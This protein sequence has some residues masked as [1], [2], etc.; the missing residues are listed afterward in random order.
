M[1]AERLLLFLLC[2]HLGSNSVHREAEG[3]RGS[4]G[5]PTPHA[6]QNF[7]PAKT[8]RQP[9]QQT[10]SAPRSSAVSWGSSVPT[11][12]QAAQPF[13]ALTHRALTPFAKASLILLAA[14]CTTYREEGRLR[15][16]HLVWRQTR[17]AKAPLS[18]DRDLPTQGRAGLGPGKYLRVSTAHPV[19]HRAGRCLVSIPAP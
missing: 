9:A 7:A 8:S 14:C 17:P 19:R 13:C 4:Y 16:W 6:K 12:P 1:K 15:S 2:L 3:E 5:R 11:S 10:G 18:S